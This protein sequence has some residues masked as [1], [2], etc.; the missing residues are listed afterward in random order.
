MTA[1]PFYNS[2][3]PDAAEKFKDANSSMYE[4]A[5]AVFVGYPS[6]KGEAA[7]DILFP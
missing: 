1:N 5:D 3:T 7:K 4:G 6:D 2:S